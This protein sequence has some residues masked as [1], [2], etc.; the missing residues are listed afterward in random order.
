MLRLLVLTVLKVNSKGVL[1]KLRGLVHEKVAQ[2]ND[3]EKEVER[4][5]FPFI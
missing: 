4:E 2:R 1:G 3:A 5:S